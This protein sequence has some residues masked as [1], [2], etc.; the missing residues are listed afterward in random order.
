MLAPAAVTTPQAGDPGD[1]NCLPTPPPAGGPWRSGC[2]SV[3]PT[4]CQCPRGPAVPSRAPTLPPRLPQTPTVPVLPSR[5]A[6]NAQSGVCTPAGG[7]VTGEHPTPSGPGR[8]RRVGGHRH[9]F[10][11]RS[12]GAAVAGLPDVALLLHPQVRAG[13]RHHHGRGPTLRRQY[14]P[15]ALAREE[16]VCSRLSCASWSVPPLGHP[17][18][19]SGLGRCPCSGSWACWPRVR[20]R[21]AP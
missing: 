13:R 20:P 2:P 18:P 10:P 9:P 19:R 17:G 15:D 21:G 6:V 3:A 8:A 1:I 5:T 14:L 7:L 4:R 16:Y 11:R 12:P